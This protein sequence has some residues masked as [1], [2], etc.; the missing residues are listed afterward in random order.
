MVSTL[1]ADLGAWEMLGHQHPGI[2][3]SSR[4][5][6]RHLLCLVQYQQSEIELLYFVLDPQISNTWQLGQILSIEFIESKA[7]FLRYGDM[8]ITGFYNSSLLV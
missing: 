6:G 5:Q 4:T 7:S 1:W 8:A 3:L 2:Q